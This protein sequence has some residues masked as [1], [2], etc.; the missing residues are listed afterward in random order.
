MRTPGKKMQIG[1]ERISCICRFALNDTLPMNGKAVEIKKS[2]VGPQFITSIG[3][4]TW[5]QTASARVT[6]PRPRLQKHISRRR[7]DVPASASQQNYSSFS[8]SISIIAQRTYPST[9]WPRFRGH[10]SWRV[11]PQPHQTCDVFITV[12]FHWQ[13]FLFIPKARR[14]EDVGWMGKGRVDW[15]ARMNRAG[16]YPLIYTSKRWR[17][18]ANFLKLICNVFRLSVALMCAAHGSCSLSYD[19]WE[20]SEVTSH[21]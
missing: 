14:Q 18:L 7:E 20:E 4:S 15:R 8:P 16:W 10:D 3:K 6:A 19:Q 11:H 17:R 21:H 13:H 12:T 9:P 5:F 2:Q 1:S